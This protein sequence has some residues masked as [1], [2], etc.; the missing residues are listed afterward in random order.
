MIQPLR[1][2]LLG[3]ALF[4]LSLSATASFAG[5]VETGLSANDA[6]VG[7]PI[8]L[9]VRVSN[10]SSHSQPVIP[11][12]QGLQIVSAGVP[13]RSSQTTII[14]GRRTDRTSVTYAWNITP[15]EPGSF[16]IPPLE[17][18]VDG[19][20]QR[21]RELQFRASK[22]E[23]GDL[24]HVEVDGKQEKIFVGQPLD[25][26][27]RVLIKPYRDSRYDVTLS[28]RDMWDLVS[29]EHSEWGAFGETLQDL[30]DSRQPV[31]AK[32]VLHTNA[33]GEPQPYY[34]YEIPA[35]IY[36]T[37]PGEVD[38]LNVQIVMQ[39]PTSLEQNRGFF[40]SGGLKIAQ[41]RPLV[42]DAQIPSTRVV[43]IPEKD[44]P[45]DYRGAVG[46][47]EMITR[48]N[49]QR[50]KAGD[51]ITLNIGIRGDGPMEL[52]QAPPL[53]EIASLTEAFKVPD[54]SLAGLVEDDVK[55]FSLDIRPRRAG[56]TEIPAL[57]FSFF[58]PQA[59]KFETVWSDP[60]P[61]QVA[62][63]DQLALSSIVASSAPRSKLESE[64]APNKSSAHIALNHYRGTDLLE[65]TA[66]AS[67]WTLLVG[68]LWAPTLF[69]LLALIQFGPR[70]TDR[71]HGSRRSAYKRAGRDLDHASSAEAVSEAL[72]RYVATVGG[73][74]PHSLTSRDAI[75]I[76]Q[77]SVPQHTIQ[78]LS[79]FLSRCDSQAYAGGTDVD[80][81]ALISDA[82]EQLDDLHRSQI[83]ATGKR[84]WLPAAG[85][86]IMCVL[87]SAIN[88]DPV[89]AT[90][91]TRLQ[92]EQVLH[93]AAEAYQE[94]VAAGDDAA[95][96]KEAFARSASKY[97]LLVDQG[98]DN[99]KLYANLASAYLQ[100]G[101]AA[102]ALANYERA[103]IYT[104]GNGDLKAG[105]DH[106]AFLLSGE[107]TLERPTILE[108]F[109]GW[110]DTI[111]VEA[112]V[113]I[114][115]FFW[116]AF[117]ITLA[118]MLHRDFRFGRKVAGF[119]LGCCLL[120]G[121]SLS[122]DFSNTESTSRGIVV[123]DRVQLR[124][125]NGTAFASLEGATLAEGSRFRVMQQKGDWLEIRTD[126]GQQGWMA[127]EAAEIIPIRSIQNT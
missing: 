69:C 117:W 38:T 57:P 95:D 67:K 87:F 8:S 101:Q 62:A 84:R 59:E 22:S 112:R 76:V 100:S 40:S 102:R 17:V 86:W 119:A 44:R 97:Q 118:A 51:P 26:V 19:R 88:A 46:R 41:A 83:Q 9:Y 25:L 42:E 56:I 34:A 80:V 52:V 11:S 103:L 70:V 54:E 77:G 98:I 75:E 73:K 110:N 81:Q 32:Q 66:P 39:Y 3:L 68:F 116:S 126:D 16:V 5:S 125:G 96:A 60:I 29:T 108:S 91:L 113:W 93:E 30:A 7:M 18:E 122:I 36:P 49:P 55:V 99:R 124:E 1:R 72:L 63:A 78:E 71:W 13:S 47:Y 20:V 90:E 107:K 121:I 28:P 127:A 31:S 50:V 82:R 65:H 10:A 111:S 21:T 115:I 4:S 89:M 48:A 43:P 104:P 6:Y 74:P 94:G 106:A 120:C 23:T 15:R 109:L 79:Q 92:Q 85:L 37:R 12:V 14:N 105:R 123:A 58:D 64:T 24:L 33:Q 53:A 45:A 61:I 114:C 35:T 27:L 2:K